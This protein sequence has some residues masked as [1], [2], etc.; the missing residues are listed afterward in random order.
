MYL[1]VCLHPPSDSVGCHKG[2]TCSN[3]IGRDRTILQK[4]IL[5]NP[6][7]HIVLMRKTVYPGNM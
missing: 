6:L 2:K 4:D 3:V 1:V 5:G 7:I